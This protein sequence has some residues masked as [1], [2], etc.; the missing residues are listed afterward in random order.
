MAS[1]RHST[2][3]GRLP[4]GRWRARYT[5]PVGKTRSVGTFDTKTEAEAAR[6]A[7]IASKAAGTWISP[8]ASAERLGDYAARWIERRTAIGGR[9]KMRATTAA[10]Y[11]AAARRFLNAP[12]MIGGQRITLGL[13]P[14]RALTPGLINDWYL[15]VIETVRAS[16]QAAHDAAAARS[17]PSDTAAARAWAKTAGHDVSSTGRLPRTTMDAWIASGSPRVHPGPCPVRQDVGEQSARSAYIMLRAVLSGA[18]KERLIASN[19]AQ[20]EGGSAFVARERPTATDA[21]VD[22]MADAMPPH[23]SALVLIAAWG[24]LR[25]GEVLGLQRRDVVFRYDSQGEIAGARLSIE[26]AV[27]V[28]EGQAQVAPPK[29]AASARVVSLPRKAASVLASH[30]NVYTASAPDAHVFADLHGGVLDPNNLGRTW[31]RVAHEVGR[32]DLH[33]HDLRHTGASALAQA[34]VPFPTLMR[35]LGHRDV[36]AAMIYQHATYDDL[37]RAADAL[38]ARL[39]SDLR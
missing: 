30:L 21:E 19:P 36:R 37:D 28:V 34:G 26:R 7:L 17:V 31:R 27:V 38:A 22:M 15:A 29:T 20:V 4:S 23:L 3:I 16:A 24:C 8:E 5:D 10:N 33:L 12:L 18:V 6:A 32:P 2:G 9:R 11:R 25:R 35:Q 39:R 14:L 1:R 13:Y